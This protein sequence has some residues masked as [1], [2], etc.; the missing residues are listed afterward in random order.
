VEQW[1]LQEIAGSYCPNG[2]PTHNGFPA[3]AFLNTRFQVP[4][5]NFNTLLRS[6]FMCLTVL[7]QNA[8]D[9]PRRACRT[10]SAGLPLPSLSHLSI[11]LQLQRD[12]EVEINREGGRLSFLRLKSEEAIQE[13]ICR[14]AMARDRSTF[15]SV[16]K[17]IITEFEKQSATIVLSQLVSAKMLSRLLA[18]EFK[19]RNRQPLAEAP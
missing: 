8:G 10:S 6:S 19:V 15:W 13:W 5:I 16:K 12:G 4:R 14:K 9:K 3:V 11:T 2:E 17:Q 7:F 18:D 1:S